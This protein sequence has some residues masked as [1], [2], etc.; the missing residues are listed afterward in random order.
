MRGKYL[1]LAFVLVIGIVFVSLC[2]LNAR[3]DSKVKLQYIK[4]CPDSR[5]CVELFN[6]F[7]IGNNEKEL[8][9]G[10][11]DFKVSNT[12]NEVTIKI[13]KLWYN[14]FNETL[15]EQEYVQLLCEYISKIVLDGTNVKLKKD[16]LDVLYKNI[17]EVYPKSKDNIEYKIESII[18]N[19]KFTFY[20]ENYELILNMEVV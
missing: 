18:N 16:E 19:I 15:Y 3:L 20:T 2:Y 9:N 8:Q 11:Y 10:Y 1:G 4:E 5:T 12:Q 6:E 13:N 14:K 17:L 7:Y